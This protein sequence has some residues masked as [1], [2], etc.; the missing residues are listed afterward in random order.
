MASGD[1]TRLN[2]K[3]LLS[4]KY[5]IITNVFT[6]TYTGNTSSPSETSLYS[7]SGKGFLL[8]AH[9]RIGSQQDVQSRARIA[10]AKILIDGTQQFYATTTGGAPGY[11]SVNSVN[12]WMGYVNKGFLFPV[13]NSST[14]IDPVNGTTIS[15]TG[16]Y[17]VHGSSPFSYNVSGSGTSNPFVCLIDSGFGI[18]FS[19]SVNFLFTSS[20]YGSDIGGF[21]LIT[22]VLLQK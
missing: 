17:C 6:P 14:M 22:R 4:E 19:S 15:L 3:G 2:F 11:S 12:V 9:L 13:A 20:M 7:F 21:Q 5:D 10:T 16:S 18:P 8:D 1:I